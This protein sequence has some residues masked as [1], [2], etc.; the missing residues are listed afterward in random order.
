MATTDLKRVAP[1]DPNDP[2]DRASLALRDLKDA[3]D[4]DEPT[5]RFEPVVVNNHI[6]MPSQPEMDPSLAP[7]EE[8]PNN[9]YA[10]DVSLLAKLLPPEH[11]IIFICLVTVVGAVLL[12]LARGWI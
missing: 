4:W 11:R 7:K 8:Q 1:P 5:G 6:T 9:A 12:A 3:D 2:L 10:K